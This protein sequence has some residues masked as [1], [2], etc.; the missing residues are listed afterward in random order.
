MHLR[1]G[2]LL[3]VHAKH[4]RVN[5]HIAHELSTGAFHEKRFTAL[6]PFD[7]NFYDKPFSYSNLE[8]DKKSDDMIRSPFIDLVKLS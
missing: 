2:L 7:I 4:N 1:S 5:R 8:F 6:F 3:A